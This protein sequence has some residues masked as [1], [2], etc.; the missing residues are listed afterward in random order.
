MWDCQPH[1]KRGQRSHDSGPNPDQGAIVMDLNGVYKKMKIRV[2]GKVI[3]DRTRKEWA[4]N[5]VWQSGWLLTNLSGVQ[6]PSGPSY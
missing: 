1:E 2:L 4:R 3:K 5:S 6:I